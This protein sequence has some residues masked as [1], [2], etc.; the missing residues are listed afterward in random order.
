MKRRACR[1]L[2]RFEV[3]VHICNIHERVQ[4]KYGPKDMFKCQIKANQN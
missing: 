1:T 3:K 4:I 2:M